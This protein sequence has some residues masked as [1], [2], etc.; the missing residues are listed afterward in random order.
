ML[1]LD[2]GGG[3]CVTHECAALTRAIPP[4]RRVQHDDNRVEERKL[5]VAA[6]TPFPD[7]PRSLDSDNYRGRSALSE[8]MLRYR[9]CLVTPRRFHSYTQVFRKKLG[10]F[11]SVVGSSSTWGQ[12]L[13]FQ[14]FSE[15]LGA[16]VE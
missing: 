14:Y 16:G 10:E 7:H 8:E 9:E 3:G 1:G 12:H 15:I 6:S 4:M 13:N 11:P 5:G 2:V